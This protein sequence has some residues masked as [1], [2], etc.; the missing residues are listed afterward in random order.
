MKKNTSTIL[1]VVVA[2]TLLAATAFA[3]TTQN[4]GYAT[5]KNLMK[6]QNN[7][8]YENGKVIGSLEVIDNGKSVVKFDGA[9]AGGKDDQSMRG[10]FKIITDSLNKELS[11]Y[12]L[13]DTF[14]LYDAEN[15]DVYVGHESADENENDNSSSYRN[16]EADYEMTSKEEA[17]MD[18]FIGDLQNKFQ[19]VKG[20]DGTYDLQFEL[21][22]SEVPTILNLL[23][24]AK[25]DENGFDRQGEKDY[26]NNKDLEAYPLFQEF[27]SAHLKVT[28]LVDEV[29]LDYIN[30][31]LDLD[32]QQ[33]IQGVQ[34]NINVTGL[35]ENGQHHTMTMTGDFTIT[36]LNTVVINP[37]DLTGK[38]IIEVP[39]CK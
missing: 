15:N 8:T 39:E 2:I 18:Y 23:V 31:V 26:F 33:E 1:T 6:T 17:I 28:D 36:E 5:F 25:N 16:S 24:S 7:S 29:E 13:D 35:D 3:G 4:T 38:N 12:G 9:F 21:T 20:T 32:A 14:Y 19:M 30:V 27:K 34:F 11:V 10:D 22:K 37:I